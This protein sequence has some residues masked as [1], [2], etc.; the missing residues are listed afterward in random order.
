MIYYRVASQDRHTAKWKWNSTALTS[1]EA[2]YRFSLPISVE[3]QLV[4]AR[5]QERVKA[6]EIL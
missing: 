4:W 5:L 6:G 1:L 3:E 2:R